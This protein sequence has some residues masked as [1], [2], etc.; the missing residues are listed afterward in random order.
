MLSLSKFYIY[1]KSQKGAFDKKYAYVSSLR[2]CNSRIIMKVSVSIGIM[3]FVLLTAP[4][5]VVLVIGR[6][7]D[8]QGVAPSAGHAAPFS[9]PVQPRGAV[10]RVTRGEAVLVCRRAKQAI[11][12]LATQCQGNTNKMP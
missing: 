11:R 6:V 12:L 1:L 3:M 7:V 9:A 10:H 8:G 2:R 4:Q 5:V